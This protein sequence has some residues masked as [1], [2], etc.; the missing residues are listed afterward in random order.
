MQIINRKKRL[1]LTGALLVAVFASGFVSSCS[2][3]LGWGVILWNVENPTI[4]SGTLV[5]VYIKS[6]IDSVYVI[7]IPKEYQVK[8]EKN[9]DP[10]INKKE[11]P[12]WQIRFFS[13]KSKARAYAKQFINYAPLYAE[14]LQDGLPI[15]SDPDNNSRRV[16]KLRQGQIV[17]VLDKAQGNPPMSGS[18]PLP[19]DWLQ[20]LTDD[21]TTGYCFSYRLRIFEIEAGKTVSVAQANTSNPEND[22]ML[23]SVL[24]KAW[25]PDWYKD[26]MDNQTIDL[27]TFTDQWGFFPSQDTGVIRIALPGFEKTYTYTAI[28]KIDTNSWRFEGSPLT[29]TLRNDTLLSVQYTLNDGTQKSSLFVNL[30]MPVSDIITQE[31][32]RRQ[33]LLETILEQGPIFQ[34]E[35]YGRLSL[36]ADGT[37]T[38]EGYDILVP[39]VIPSTAS[40]TGTIVMRLFI[41]ESIRATY[42]GALTMYFNPQGIDGQPLPVEPGKAMAVNFLYK[43]EPGA[44][45]LEYL[46]PSS[47]SGTMVLQRSPSPIILYFPASEQ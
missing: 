38:W 40:G 8:P 36:A 20:V 4:P 7:G 46:P 43:V 19:G 32:A 2:Q 14:T 18:T 1:A 5:P 16:Y 27:D 11:V 24:S 33:K 34:N 31:Q 42:D 47:L 26:M 30:P 12:L 25:S 15:R 23:E 13:S 41:R 9:S 17:K 39:R 10:I 45:R 22:P 37:F 21:G 28:T 6:N 29:I 3:L 35:N 44:L